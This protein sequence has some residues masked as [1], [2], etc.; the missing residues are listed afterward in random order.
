MVDF[1]RRHPI[2]T[3]RMP[4]GDG[5]SQR[6]WTDAEAR[7]TDQISPSILAADFGNLAAEIRATEEGGAD[8]I[9]LDVM[10]GV[11]AQHHPL[12]RCWSFAVPIMTD[13]PLDVHLMVEDP[14][15][16]LDV[17]AEAG[18]NLHGARGGGAPHQP[19][20]AAHHGV[21]LRQGVALNPSTAVESVREV[22]PFVDM[23][24]V[25]SVNPGFGSQ[26]F[27]ETSTEQAAPHA[28][29][30]GPAQSGLRSAS[31]RRRGRAQHRRRGA[32]GR[33]CHRGRQ[34]G[35]QRPRTVADNIAALRDALA[36]AVVDCVGW[37]RTNLSR[38]IPMSTRSGVGAKEGVRPG[39]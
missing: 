38:R 29:V 1:L 37:R 19:H 10:D 18:A 23:V 27:I 3:A 16:Y 4:Q 28:P 21:G 30:A 2:S 31:R 15:R 17:F 11:C 34:R 20:A 22:M 36:G 5:L 9:H 8:M 14:D 7:A 33:Q 6:R 24:L 25:M 39:R 26:R 12:G 32:F 35:L 13:L